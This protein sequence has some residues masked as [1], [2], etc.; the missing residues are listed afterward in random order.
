MINTMRLVALPR[1]T[2]D[3]LDEADRILDELAK[4]HGDVFDR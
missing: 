3:E 1:V 4:K 2:E